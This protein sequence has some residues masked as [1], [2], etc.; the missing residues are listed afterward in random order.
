MWVWP[1][2]VFG[3]SPPSPNAIGGPFAQANPLHSPLSPSLFPP[4]PL[5]L[6]ARLREGE[7]QWWGGA[8][9]GRRGVEGGGGP[10]KRHLGLDPHLGALECGSH[11]RA[12]HLCCFYEL[13]PTHMPICFLKSSF[14]AGFLS[15]MW[16]DLSK[17]KVKEGNEHVAHTEEL[18]TYAASMN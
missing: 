4:P 2:L 13:V 1:Q 6:F 18:F 10:S 12:I 16:Q 11:R 7:A 8:V 14:A 3:G 17:A 15:F 5:A 9:L